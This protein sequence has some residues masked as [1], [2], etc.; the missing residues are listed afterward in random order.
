MIVT[1]TAVQAFKDQVNKGTGGFYDAHVDDKGK[2]TLVSTGMEQF[3]GAPSMSSKQYAFVNALNDAINS[4]ATVEIETVSS[5]PNVQV[6]NIVTNQ[7]DMKDIAAFDEAGPGGG[8]SPGA[9]GHEI[10]EQQMKAEGGGVKGV[11]P[12]GSDGK[13]AS[14]AHRQGIKT[15]CLI[16]GNIRSENVPQN[17]I[18]TF[19]E[20]DGTKTI[21]T[22]ES[23][24]S[25]AIKVTKTK[26][27]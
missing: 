13:L 15:E 7:I 25:G 3:D 6:G 2:V 21:Q 17:G 27:K 10:K 4:K 11:Y 24:S 18:D 16:N 22:I 14:R 8:T 26:V 19:A 5:D 12:M 9:L 20:R 23:L 1:G